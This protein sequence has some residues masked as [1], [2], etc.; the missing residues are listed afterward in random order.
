MKGWLKQKR[1]K[2]IDSWRYCEVLHKGDRVICVCPDTGNELINCSKAFFDSEL[3]QR[4]II[5]GEG[6]H[7]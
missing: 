4:R 2:L 1:H 5:V 7:E 6:P 3:E